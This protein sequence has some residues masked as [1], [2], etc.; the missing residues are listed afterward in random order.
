MYSTA[1]GW[2]CESNGVSM[3]PGATAFTRMPSVITYLARAFVRQI[4]PALESEY[5]ILF[6]LPSLP[7]ME[8]AT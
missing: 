1:S 5:G 3:T 2:S 7:E 6:G 4:T 8:A